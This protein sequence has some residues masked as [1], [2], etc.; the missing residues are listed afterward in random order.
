MICP[1]CATPY[2]GELVAGVVCRD[3]GNS[4]IRPRN[5]RGISKEYS[6]DYFPADLQFLTAEEQAALVQQWE[7][8]LVERLNATNPVKLDACRR[9]WTKALYDHWSLRLGHIAHYNRQG[10]FAAQ[11]ANEADL[12][13]NLDELQRGLD[14]MGYPLERPPGAYRMYGK[15]NHLLGRITRIYTIPEAWDALG[16]ES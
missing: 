9:W 3:C 14:H 7:R 15:L 8:F 1:Y 16:P 11:W 12:L 4:L 6:P 5:F 10:F 2:A 13:R